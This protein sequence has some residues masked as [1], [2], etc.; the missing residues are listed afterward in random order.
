M[1]TN[2]GYIAGI[3]DGEAYL[4]IRKSTYGMRVSKDCRNPVYSERIQIKMNSQDV[5]QVF[6]KLFGGRL[7]HEPRIY[8]SKIATEKGIKTNK[9]M[10]LYLATDKKAFEIA[11][12][13]YP[14]VIEKKKQILCLL[15]L[16]ESKESK[17]AKKRGGPLKRPM[18]PSIVEYREKLYQTVKNL[19]HSKNVAI[20]EMPQEVRK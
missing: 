1:K 14:Y 5:L 12:K 19:N 8:Q 15:K 4:G 7:Y 3:I 9:R 2:L 10:W 16:R 13:V 17:L 20:P 11:K 18:H 6:K